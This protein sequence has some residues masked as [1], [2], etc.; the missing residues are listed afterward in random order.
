MIEA[1]ICTKSL[2]STVSQITP[3]KSARS[4]PAEVNMLLSTCNWDGAPNVVA[5]VIMMMFEVIA[6]F[7]K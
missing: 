1:N 2:H 6:T 3:F 4:P 7:R 5:R